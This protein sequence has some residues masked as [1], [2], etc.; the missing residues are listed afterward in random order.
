MND[1]ILAKI[2]NSFDPSRPLPAGD[3]QYVDCRAVRG[4]EDIVTDLGS[5]IRKA[6]QMTYQLYTGHRGS[7]K[8]TELSAKSNGFKMNSL[9]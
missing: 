1:D 9:N 5:R 2:Y 4:D 6:D 7:S 3:P 8:S